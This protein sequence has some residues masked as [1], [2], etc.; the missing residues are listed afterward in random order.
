MILVFNDEG[1]LPP[2]DYPMTFSQIRKSLLVKKP[3]NYGG[4]WDMPWRLELVNNLE[5][6][7]KHLWAVK[8]TEIFINGSFVEDKGHPNDIDGYFE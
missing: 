1:I 6:L 2:G 5:I 4:L 8:I 3:K 7:V